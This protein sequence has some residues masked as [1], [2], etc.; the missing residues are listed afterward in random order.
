MEVQIEV[1]LEVGLGNR[2]GLD[3][4]GSARAAVVGHHRVAVRLARFL[5]T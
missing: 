2:Q 3:G 5:E 1:H 4:S